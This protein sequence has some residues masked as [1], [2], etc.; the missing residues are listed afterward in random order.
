MPHVKSNLREGCC[1]IFKLP[2]QWLISTSTWQG[3]LPWSL[4]NQL[5]GLITA[6]CNIFLSPLPHEFTDH[7]S[8]EFT[9]HKVIFISFKNHRKS[10]SAIQFF[11]SKLYHMSE[12]KI[13]TQCC[14]PLS[15]RR[16]LPETCG[17]YW[18]QNQILKRQRRLPLLRAPSLPHQS[19]IDSLLTWL[20]CP[21][22][23][24]LAALRQR[25]SHIAIFSTGFCQQERIREK[26][27]RSRCRRTCF[28]S[29]V[30]K[31]IAHHSIQT[32]QQL[33]HM[34]SHLAH[35]NLL[36]L[37]FLFCPLS[38][39]RLL[40]L[41]AIDVQSEKRTLKHQKRKPDL[42]KGHTITCREACLVRLGPSLTAGGNFTFP[43]SSLP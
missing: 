43:D 33:L 25:D 13:H 28:W 3:L 34:C 8:L 36:F 29:T 32:T 18:K 10:L 38:T 39:W 16:L 20:W 15:L 6:V 23:F 22:N 19:A 31:C 4:T 2:L 12:L 27:K 7:D 30:L 35:L 5:L 21:S 11:S 41:Q 40:F 17:F 9:L 24:F 42:E 26:K 37:F 14:Y 1:M